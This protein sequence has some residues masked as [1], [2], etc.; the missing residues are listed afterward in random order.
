MGTLAISSVLGRDYPM[1]MGITMIGAVMI[2]FSNLLADVHLCGDRS[3]HQ[4]LM[5]SGATQ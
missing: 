5:M 3:A 2:V 1:I 4:I